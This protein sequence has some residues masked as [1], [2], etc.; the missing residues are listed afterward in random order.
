MIN[1]S[2]I[3]LRIGRRVIAD[4]R[5]SRSSIRWRGPDVATPSKSVA[6]WGSATCW[7]GASG[8]DRHKPHSGPLNRFAACLGIGGIV[9]VG[10]DG[11]SEAHREPHR[12]CQC[13]ARPKPAPRRGAAA[14]NLTCGAEV[15]RLAAGEDWI[16]SL[17]YP[18]SLGNQP[19][20]EAH[21]IFFLR[22]LT[23]P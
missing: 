8:D 1:C 13:G 17:A 18:K 15:R 12:Q 21:G 23:S 10:L 2:R 5:A 3:R 14:F 7:E 20:F 19:F 16:R 11:H 22:I 9:F 6:S 4:S